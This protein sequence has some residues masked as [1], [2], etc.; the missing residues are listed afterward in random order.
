VNIGHHGFGGAEEVSHIESDPVGRSAC[1]SPAPENIRD[2]VTVLAQPFDQEFDQWFD[3]LHLPHGRFTP[4]FQRALRSTR[5][6]SFTPH[7][8]PMYA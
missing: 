5:L 6:P 2:G 1:S 3:Q 7:S 4:D 8:R